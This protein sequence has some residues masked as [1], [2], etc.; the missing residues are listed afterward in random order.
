MEAYL[1]V[2]DLK[3]LQGS[4]ELVRGLSFEVHRGQVLGLWGPS[5]CGKSLT[6]MA[7][8]DLLPPGLSRQGQ[9]LLEGRPLS[10]KGAAAL[11]GSRIA[12][13]LQNPMS[14]FDPLFT[15]RSHF[16]ETL[17]AHSRRG[18]DGLYL[19]ALEEVGL[20][21]PKLLDRYPFQMSG[22]QLQRVMIA[23]A[24]V[25]EAPF[26]IADEA[27]TDL[28]PIAQDQILDLLEDLIRR[29]NLG[30]ILVTHHW[31][32]MARLAGEVMVMEDG[33]VLRRLCPKLQAPQAQEL[34]KGRRPSDPPLSIPNPSASQEEGI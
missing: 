2:R 8:M 4:R 14:C 6:C 18:H 26:L 24:L 21:E 16:A 34:L 11:R 33:A 30:M 9:V 27:T 12:A 22:G 32:V 31:A 25:M 13:I 20:V 3:V 10:G 1:Q 7:L 15:L 17:R 29:R 28:D 23:L 5:G 19:Q